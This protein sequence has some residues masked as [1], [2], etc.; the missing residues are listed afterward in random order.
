[1]ISN[2]LLR[3]TRTLTS[4]SG[5]VSAVGHDAVHTN[6]FVFTRITSSQGERR[7]RRRF[8]T[9]IGNL[10]LHPYTIKMSDSTEVCLR[11][12]VDMGGSDIKFGATN[13]DADQILLSELVKLPSLSQEGPQKTISQITT[14]IEAV[15]A[16]LGATW[17][18]V[19]DIAVTVPCP[20]SSDGIILEVTNLGTPETKHLWELPFGDLLAEAVELKAGYEISVFACNDANAAGQ[21]DDFIRYGLKNPE[22]KNRGRTSVFITTGTGL[23]GCVLANGSVFYGLGQAGELGHLKI[24]I[25][26]NY[27]NR[28]SADPNPPCGCGGYQ[29]VETRASL[30]GLIRRITWALS[31]EGI[32]LIREELEAEGKQI[33]PEVLAKLQELC[34]QA[35]K[36]AAYEVRTFADKQEDAFCRWLLEDWAIMIGAL[37]ASIGPVLHPNLF[38]I[39]GGL[40]EM[41]DQARDW[42]LAVVRRA[43]DTTNA[44]RCFVRQSCSEKG[45][46]SEKEGRSGKGT[47][48]CEIVWSKSASADQGWRGAILMGMRARKS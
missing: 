4:R 40:T 20:C 13:L 3:Q 41:S 15:L 30:T 43:Y 37:F 17:S 7:C 1:V 46:R 34:N 19:A 28:F 38:I 11:I 32:A 22:F 12:G 44:Q 31:D 8:V 9:M 25:P 27:A 14:G 35:P 33:N 26:A 16:E 2:G 5:I 10:P 23:G 29:C 24:A 21:D 39:G 42:F 47:G 45:S 18:Q 48:N 36:R 6:D